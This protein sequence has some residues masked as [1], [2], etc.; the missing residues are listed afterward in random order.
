MRSWAC[1]PDVRWI[2]LLVLCLTAPSLHAQDGLLGI[3]FDSSGSN[4][5]GSVGVASYAVLYVVLQPAGSTYAGVTAAEFRVDASGASGYLVANEHIIAPVS[6]GGS[7]LGSGV[8]LAFQSCQ[9]GPV[10]FLSF[11]VLNTGSGIEDGILRI[12][13]RQ[14]PSNPAFSCPVAVLCDDPVYTEVCVDAGYAL[15]NPSG[16]RTCAGGRLPA[17]WSRV[18]GLYRP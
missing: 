5:S 17:E 10:A 1:R 15:L 12:V 2:A 14:R 16:S 4:C 7:A 13:A 11:Q 9:N 8:T 3:F 18:K 6:A